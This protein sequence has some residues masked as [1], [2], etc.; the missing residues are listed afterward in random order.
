MYLTVKQQLKHLSKEEYQSLRYLCHVAKNLVNQA[1]YNVRQYYFQETQYLNYQKTY[2]LLKDSENY[3][4]LNS[5]MAQQILKDVDGSFQSFFK[6]RKLAKS[7]KYPMHSV[8]LPKYLPKDGYATLIIGMIRLNED[9]TLT[10]PMSQKYKKTH[11]KIIIRIPKV[12]YDKKIKEIRIVP[13]QRARFFEVQ[14]I[15]EIEC[16]QR[17]LNE[18]K[19]LAVDFGIDNLMTCVTSEGQSFIIDGKRL[20]AENQWY[21]KR[22]AYLQ[23]IKDKQKLQKKYT[24]QMQKITDKR[25]RYVMDYIHKSAKKVID[26]CIQNQIGILVVGYNVTFQRN[27]RMGRKTNQKFVMIPYGKLREILEYLCRLNG[28]QYVQQE[29]SYTSK[30]SFWDQDIILVYNDDNPKTYTFSGKRVHRGLY[31][32]KSGMLLNADVNGALNIMRKSNVVSLVA[33]YSRGE[34]DTPARIRMA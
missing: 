15:Y 14:Y 10:L 34:V 13:K 31:K 24:C 9:H 4:L 6:L 16:I 21:N 22:I 5:N 33:L 26:Y 1:V 30:A 27:V 3:K 18:Q 29:E 23:S 7:G 11:S 8:K 20:K 19:A 32:T 17:N 2:A 25:Y 12:L 28:I